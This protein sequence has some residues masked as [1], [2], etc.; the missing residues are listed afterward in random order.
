MPSVLAK[1]IVP[2]N[3]VLTFGIFKTKFLYHL[4]FKKFKKI[5]RNLVHSIVSENKLEKIGSTEPLST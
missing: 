5:P 2:N 3:D 1:N 4:G